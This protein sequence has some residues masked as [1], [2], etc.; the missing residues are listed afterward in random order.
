MQGGVHYREL[1]AAVK[2]PAEIKNNPKLYEAVTQCS[3]REGYKEDGVTRMAVDGQATS[4]AQ[5][6]G[7]IYLTAVRGPLVLVLQ[8]R[9]AHSEDWSQRYC[10]LV[11]LHAKIF[12]CYGGHDASMA[13]YSSVGLVFDAIEREIEPF[14][15]Y[16]A[17]LVTEDAVKPES[18][19][20]QPETTTAAAA[21]SESKR[22][23]PS[24]AEA[25]HVD[26]DVSDALKSKRS[27][28]SPPE[29]AAAAASDASLEAPSEPAA[30][31]KPTST[32]SRKKTAAEV[33]VDVIPVAS[34]KAQ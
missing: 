24:E 5:V 22:S 7:Q 26:S 34:T 13:S 3:F 4:I 28:T 19:K 32:S 30:K 18:K 8:M 9:H 11:D 15:T 1:L 29:A 33:S 20:S 21:A 14:S 16:R 6:L 27:K 25:V 17:V 31:K 10:I 23:K 12:V 2:A